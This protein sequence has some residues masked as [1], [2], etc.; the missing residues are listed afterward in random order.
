MSAIDGYIEFERQILSISMQGESLQEFVSLPPDAWSSEQHGDIH[1]AICEVFIQGDEADP[2]AV[3]KQ[4]TAW[5]IHHTS[6]DDLFNLT[7]NWTPYG[8]LSRLCNQLA[9]Q[10]N[11]RRVIEAVQAAVELSRD[12]ENAKAAQQCALGKI[13]SLSEVAKEDHIFPMA[14][15]LKTV[16]EE[17]RTAFDRTDEEKAQAA[18][19]P[20]GIRALDQI[21]DGF[22]SGSLYILGAG[23]GRGKS[24]M[25]LQFAM[26]A[27]E[28]DRRAMFVSLEMS[29]V[30]LVRRM[31]AAESRVSPSV[32]QS[33][34]LQ[35]DEIERLTHASTRLGRLKER[36]TIYDQPSLSLYQL[37]A[38]VRTMRQAGKIDLVIVDYLQLLRTDESYSREREVATISAGLVAIART[39]D[40]PVIALSQL[41][42]NGQIRESRAVSHDAAGVMRID[43]E[44]DAWREGTEPIQCDLCVL[45]HRHG[46]TGRVPLIFERNVQ[47]FTERVYGY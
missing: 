26:A 41:N 29:H 15:G 46:R 11:H 23:T 6:L 38:T 18:G 37:A 24:V 30:D 43:Y 13:L 22:R 34:M 39:N 32:I 12:A 40:I 25:G 33:G 5:G 3:F 2:I 21:L 19:V 7:T 4:L 8:Q 14:A 16:I 28:A 45:K 9:D 35:G 47:R 10:A 42:D 44:Q 20:T 17:C 1:R 36:L 27:I 31:V